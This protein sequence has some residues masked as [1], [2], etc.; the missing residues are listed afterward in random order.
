[1]VFQWI[2]LGPSLSPPALLMFPFLQSS[3]Q[4]NK[5]KKKNPPQRW[6]H[7]HFIAFTRVQRETVWKN[8]TKSSFWFLI[9]AADLCQRSR[10]YQHAAAPLLFSAFTFTNHSKNPEHGFVLPGTRNPLIVIVRAK[11]LRVLVS[12]L[13]VCKFSQH[14]LL[15]LCITEDP[16][17]PGPSSPGVIVHRIP[18]TVWRTEIYCGVD[19]SYSHQGRT[20]TTLPIFKVRP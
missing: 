17:S 19:T 10:C 4:K 13:F 8:A 16:Q 9:R 20:F 6:N 5:Q 12:V 2:S 14:S 1:M 15:K 18:E 3:G 11:T 7:S